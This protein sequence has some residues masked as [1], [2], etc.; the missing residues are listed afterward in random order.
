MKTVNLH[1]PIYHVLFI[2]L[3]IVVAYSNT[4]TVPFHLDDIPVI[5]ENPRIKSLSNISSLYKDIEGHGGTEPF[6]LTTFAIN[7]YLGGL[8]TFGYHVFNIIIHTINGILLYFFILMTAKLLN[9]TEKNIRPIAFFSSLV[10]VTHPIQTECVTNI[11]G[12]TTPLITVFYLT[13]ILLFVKAVSS[14][15]GRPFYIMALFLSSLLGMASRENFVTFPFMLL[16]Y[17]FFF[18]SKYRLKSVIGHYKIH[19]PVILTLVYFAYLVFY[20]DYEIIRIGLE[21]ASPIEYLMT[22]TNVHW[23]Y[24][25]LLVLPV[26]QNLD[27]D[28]PIARTLFEFPTIFSFI[29]YM[30]IWAAGLYYLKRRPVISFGI[31]WFLITLS[32][33]SSIIP[34]NNMIFEHRMYLP[35][36]G[37]FVAAGAC[38]YIVIEKLNHRWEGRTGKAAVAIC[39]VIIVVLT[40]VTYARN[41]IWKEEVTLWE[42]VV[43][44]SPKKERAQNNLGNA[45]RDKGM[46]NRAEEHLK[47]ALQI[48]PDYVVAYNNLGYTY[49]LKG[50]VDEAIEQYMHALALQP[51]NVQAL[52][53]LGKAYGFKGEIDKAIKY[54][55]TAISITSSITSVYP[56]PYYNLGLAYLEKGAHDMAI[57]YMKAALQIKPDYA[58]AY[59]NLGYIYYQ[60]G[61]VDEAI[62]QYRMA[63]NLDHDIPG[64]HYNLSAAYRDKGLTDKAKEH[65]EKAIRLK[66]GETIQP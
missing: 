34:F 47:T 50:R 55:K 18:V 22:Q 9:Y 24:L 66:Q 36:I 11:I 46:L 57:K 31:L 59:N 17:D 64:V 37:I 10:F 32:P 45:Y 2:I 30:G 43:R 33:V 39:S 28:Y 52:N 26:N 62:A 63:I 20:G 21:I 8:N 3:F 5:V 41:T 40:G 49:Y 44:K 13:G 38:V 48:N 54:L 25:R 23:T 4:L 35:S 12:R 1:K 27:Y 15:K 58:E 51:V 16:L 29:G 56:E 19:L 61:Q 53:N 65:Y 14:D 7:Y 6:A 60:K 42:D